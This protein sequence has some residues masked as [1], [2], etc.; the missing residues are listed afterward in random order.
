M[1]LTQVKFTVNEFE[2]NNAL[3]WTWLTA[4]KGCGTSLLEKWSSA[5][6]NVCLERL[7]EVLSAFVFGVILYFG[8]NWSGNQIADS[9]ILE[10][11]YLMAH[12]LDFNYSHEYANVAV[13]RLVLFLGPAQESVLVAPEKLADFSFTDFFKGE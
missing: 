13:T 6:F 9:R 3:S 1:A 2:P 5:A 4:R 11:V 10:K 7:G 8:W 12:A